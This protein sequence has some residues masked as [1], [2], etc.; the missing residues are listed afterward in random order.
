MDNEKSRKS[1]G[2][3]RKVLVLSRFFFIL[4]LGVILTASVGCAGVTKGPVL[5]R[6]SEDRAALMWETEVKGPGKVLYGQDNSLR[7]KVTTEPIRVEYGINKKVAFIHKTWLEN[8]QPGQTYSYRVTSQRTPV[9]QRIATLGR[10]RVQSK[11]YKFRTVPDDTNEVTFLVYGDT[12]TR[13]EVHRLV[14]EQML[15]KKVDFVV[16]SGDLVSSGDHYEQFGPQFFEPVKG[17]AETVPFYIAKGNHEGKKGNFEK[18]LVPDGQTNTFGFDYGPVHFFC[19]DN[20]S[21]DLT[22]QEQLKQIADDARKSKAQWKFVSFHKPSLNFGGHW[23]DWGYPDAL[24]ILSEAG[25]DFVMTGHSHQYERF[26]PVAPLPGTDGGYVTHITCGGGGAPSH[27]V[28]PCLYHAQAKVINHFC[29][30]NINDNRLT[31]D[32]FD[33]DGK[34]IDHLEI[35]KTN[36]RLNEQYLW[37]AVP[38]AAVRLHQD[39]HKN[40]PAQLSKKP[41]KDQSFNVTYKLSVP[42]LGEPAKITFKLDCDE[43]TYKLPE[44]KT[45]TIPKEGGTFKVEL[46]ATPLTEVKV[47]KNKKP[48]VPALR[49]ECHYEIG[50]IKEHISYSIIAKS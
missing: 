32:T 49:L 11:V 3:H 17:L 24:R 43:R 44:P 10:S 41:K 42:A 6:V 9:L 14:V 47:P 16:H 30:F 20:Y 34:V 21:S 26:R 38:V 40:Q 15:D 28:K 29:L 37:T 31:M 2:V 48:I 7:K 50:R 19:V 27:D 8:L 33:I 46:A 45:L 4:A 1:S 22:A 18:L 5:L 25:V 13:P 23:S 39:L 36:G 35:V 12:R